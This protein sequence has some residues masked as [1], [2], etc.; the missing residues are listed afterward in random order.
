METRLIS[1]WIAST[2]ISLLLAACSSAVNIT[3]TA[4]NNL[5]LATEL[6]MGTLKLEGS[7]AAPT[8]EQAGELLALWKAYQALSSS[9]S[10]AQAELDG[11]VA[12]IQENMTVEQ[13]Q[14]IASMQLSS[15]SQDAILLSFGSEGISDSTQGGS[16]TPVA[17]KQDPGMRPAGDGAGMPE[18]DPAMGADTQF[19]PQ[20]S[21]LASSSTQANSPLEQ[22]SPL[23][24]NALIDALEAQTQIAS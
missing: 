6:A 5:S 7:T 10:I 20:A 2:A 17:S 12:Q 19:M 24:I 11:L 23:L 21:T 16:Q 14:A 9:D 15:L 18:G 13:T 22:V 4:S 3:S 8:P 1:L